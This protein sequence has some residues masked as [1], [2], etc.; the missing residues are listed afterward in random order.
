VSGGV[1]PETAQ[2]LRNV[3]AILVASGSGLGR[4]ARCTVYLVDLADF[5]AMNEVWNATFPEPRPARATVGVAALV[6]GARVEMECTA[7]RGA[8]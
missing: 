7:L 2:L 4:V 6:L 5:A 3:E 8:G 1:G